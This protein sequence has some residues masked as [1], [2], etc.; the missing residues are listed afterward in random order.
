MAATAI[1]HDILIAYLDSLVLYS[2]HSGAIQNKAVYLEL[3]VNSDS[4]KG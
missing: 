2:R 3:G 1:K 4:E